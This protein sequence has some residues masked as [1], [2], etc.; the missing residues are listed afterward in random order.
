LITEEELKELWFR[1]KAYLMKQPTIDR[2]DN[3]KNYTFENC[4]FLEKNI[5]DKKSGKEKS[6]LFINKTGGKN[7]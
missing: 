7:V 5:H 1:N 6:L 3:N 2:K 4:Q